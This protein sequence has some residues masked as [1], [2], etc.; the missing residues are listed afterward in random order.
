MGFHVFSLLINFTS[1]QRKRKRKFE[2]GKERR[3]ERVLVNCITRLLRYGRD[4]LKVERTM[5]VRMRVEMRQVS[6]A[7]MTTAIVMTTTITT[8]RQVTGPMYH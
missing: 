1:W 5:R 2:M 8:D 7:V 3:L 6:L 4:F